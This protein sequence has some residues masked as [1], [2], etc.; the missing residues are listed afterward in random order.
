MLCAESI[1]QV[2]VI[3]QCLSIDGLPQMEVSDDPD[4]GREDEVM[5]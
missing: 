3:G 4:E 2:F 5:T 1:F